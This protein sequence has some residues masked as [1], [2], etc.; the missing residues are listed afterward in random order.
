MRRPFLVSA[1]FVTVIQIC[2]SLGSPPATAQTMPGMPGMTMRTPAP[3]PG[4]SVKPSIKPSATPMSMPGMVM[5]TTSPSASPAA[6]PTPLPDD[7]M[8]GM[9]MTAAP[10]ATA[11]AVPSMEMG[12][13]MQ[14]MRSI[15]NLAETMSQ[16]GSGTS[17]VPRSTQMFGWSQMHGANMTMEHGAIF[18]R[19]VATGSARG[20]RRFDAPNWFMLMASHAFGD[21][22]QLGFRG[23]LS[24]DALTENQTGYP[25]LFQSG[26]TAHGVA[27]HDH[28]HPHDLFAELALDYSAKI[29]K[30][31][32]LYGYVGYPGEPALGP[33]VYM[34][35]RIAYDMPD[36]TIGHHWMD[37]THIQFG[38]AT[39][40]FAPSSHFKIE[41][42][43]FTGRE[44][45]EI[46]TNFDAIHLDSSSERLSWNPNDNVAVQIS[47]GFI[48]SPEALDPKIDVHRVTASVLLNRAIGLD[49]N[50]YNGFVFGQN[51]ESGGLRTNAF[52]A[53]TDYQMGRTSVF[54][55][56]ELG[57]RSARDLV[58][59]IANPDTVY[60]VGSYS[61]GAVRDLGKNPSAVNFGLGA[62]VSLHSK[63]A[64]LQS[65]YGAGTPLDY[66]IYLRVRP[67]DMAHAMGAMTGMSMH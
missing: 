42:S 8:P 47:Y 4:A 63:S 67:P 54:A 6:S 31:A 41:G 65:V 51:I 14:D 53:E 59:P 1:A 37:A 58:I 30:D 62:E 61:F 46:R 18:P 26:E 57:T 21:R 40:G 10:R 12:G 11:S 38:V 2:A 17:W 35:R 19:Y 44:P 49:H 52:L 23:M 5:A 64:G 28:Q 56:L 39:L 3:S 29:G 22:S 9:T 16:E 34:H 32:S 7:G 55:R 27:L 15:T 13:T 36:A 20:D 60:T 33:P 45:N 24:A 25:L 48:K 50:W 66:Q 43:T